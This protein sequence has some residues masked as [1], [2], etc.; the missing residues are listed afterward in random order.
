[1][2]VAYLRN[3]V[4]VCVAPQEWT[5]PESLDYDDTQDGTGAAIGHVW[6]GAA[7]YNPNAAPAEPL[8]PIDF[9]RRF[10]PSEWIAI[11][12]ARE[13]D[14]MVRYVMGLFSAAQSVRIDHPDTQSA[15]AYFVYVGLLTQARAD[16]IG[17]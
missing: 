9:M 1:M 4:V 11:D 3:G 12:A 13:T 16:E 10:T 8:P 17:A 7:Y 6:T 15:L 5:P 14:G 2:N